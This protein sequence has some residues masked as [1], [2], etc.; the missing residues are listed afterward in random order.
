MKGLKHVGDV[1]LDDR[2]FVRTQLYLFELLFQSSMVWISENHTGQS[3]S[4]FDFDCLEELV[5]GSELGFQKFFLFS[6]FSCEFEVL[7]SVVFLKY[8]RSDKRLPY[9]LEVIVVSA[10][11]KVE[12]IANES[13]QNENAHHRPH[14]I[15]LV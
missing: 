9:V 2:G 5:P 12:Q 11:S 15:L 1:L 7:D 14:G 13:V 6:I 4:F 3:F 10:I 8:L